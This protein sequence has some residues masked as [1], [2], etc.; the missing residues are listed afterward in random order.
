MGLT[1]S[2]L[3]ER[4]GATGAAVARWERGERQPRAEAA[5][6]LAAWLAQPAMGLAPSA[7]VTIAPDLAEL[8]NQLDADLGTLFAT[9]GAEAVRAELKR[10]W[11]ARNKAAIAARNAYFEKEGLPL[12]DLRFL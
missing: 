12:A 11:Q 7:A 1:Q 4:L 10:L 5:R 6:R 2:E 3:G 9:I 8:A